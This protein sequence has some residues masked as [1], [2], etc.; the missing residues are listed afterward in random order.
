MRAA[1]AVE[2]V[3]RRP[4]A[5]GVVDADLLAGKNM[6]QGNDRDLSVEAAIGIAAVI[7]EIRSFIRRQRG[8]IKI[9][10]DLNG[11]APDL[12]RQFV[13]RVRVHDAAA[14]HG[15]DLAGSNCFP[16]EHRLAAD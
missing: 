3:V 1:A 4:I 10:L 2:F 12:R 5:H 13:Q 6:P 14:P 11:M 15:D 16:G 8:E 9:L 7:D